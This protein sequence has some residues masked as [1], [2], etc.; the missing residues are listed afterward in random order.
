MAYKMNDFVNTWGVIC[1][2]FK[3]TTPICLSINIYIFE[4][5]YI[6]SCAQNQHLA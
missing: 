5:T 3:I 1:E 4:D 6:E 2:N